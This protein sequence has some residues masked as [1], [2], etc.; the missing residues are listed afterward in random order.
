[1]KQL[2]IILLCSTLAGQAQTTTAS[3]DLSREQQK[4]ERNKL[5]WDDKLTSLSLHGDRKAKGQLIKLKT[6]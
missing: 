1:M 6:A 3:F 5:N 2:L 4:E